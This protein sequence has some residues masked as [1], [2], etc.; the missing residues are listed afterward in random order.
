MCPR[1]VL[2]ILTEVKE[3]KTVFNVFILCVLKKGMPPNVDNKSA[4]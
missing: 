1:G 4:S 3:L 2:K